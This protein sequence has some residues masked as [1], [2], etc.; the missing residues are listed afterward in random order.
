MV[1][2]WLQ[3][4]RGSLALET[5]LAAGEILVRQVH[6]A[7]T[8]IST[9]GRELS[10]LLE[11]W[12]LLCYRLWGCMFAINKLSTSFMDAARKRGRFSNRERQV[13]VWN[14]E[15]SNRGAGG[16]A[17][18]GRHCCD[19]VHAET[20][21]TR[22]SHGRGMESSIQRPSVLALHSRSRLKGRRHANM[23]EPLFMRAGQTACLAEAKARLVWRVRS[24][25]TCDGSLPL[26]ILR[27]GGS[28]N[29][30]QSTGSSTD[31]SCGDTRRYRSPSE[32][33]VFAPGACRLSPGAR[34]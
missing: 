27:T 15:I 22:R 12:Y 20:K 4:T 25:R 32:E 29:G 10:I 2:C 16:R 31:E 7:T 3:K 13:S 28:V 21:P 5:C 14:V 1:G 33:G 19:N 26:Y 9:H 34:I 24:R 17:V 11:C 18:G 23:F 6:A 8:P 30:T